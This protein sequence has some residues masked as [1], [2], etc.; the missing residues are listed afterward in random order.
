MSYT[1]CFYRANWVI[2]NG[3]KY[4]TPC[5]L[6]IGKTEEED[7]LF[8]SV[9]RV[10]LSGQELF[11]EFEQMDAVFYQHYHAYCL[12]PSRKYFLI[13]HNDLITFH[14]YGLYHCPHISN[15]FSSL[16]TVLRSNTYIP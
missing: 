11:F 7:P 15:T 4:Q 9:C 1:F 16:Y 12:T 2:V 3:T 14:P 8:G 10:L 5:L 13:K 6:I